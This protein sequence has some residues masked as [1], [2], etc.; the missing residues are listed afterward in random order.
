ME[1]GVPD[2]A[3]LQNLEDAGC[4]C[5]MVKCYCELEAQQK[6]MP[7]IRKDQIRLLQGQRRALLNQLHDS[8]KKIDCLDFLLYKLKKQKKVS[9]E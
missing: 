5:D 3:T 9:E 2:K 4:D 8:Q 6:G 7:L 1:Q